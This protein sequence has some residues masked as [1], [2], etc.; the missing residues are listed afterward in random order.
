MI[1]R[2]VLAVAVVAG[3]YRVDLRAPA[4]AAPVAERAAAYERLRPRAVADPLVLADGTTVRYAEDV[5]PVV[6]PDGAAAAHAR[7]AARAR[8]GWRRSIYA[9][10]GVA[11]A[12][13]VLVV[14]GAEN[15]GTSDLPERGPTFG[16]GVA[17]FIAGGA[18]AGVGTW[19]FGARER[20][21]RRA[22][23]AAYDEGLRARLALCVEGLA[24]VACPE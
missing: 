8:R 23:F 6:A 15:R 17:L 16:P 21:A 1:A 2:L 10:I 18:V 4:P 20:E 11:A 22:A 5:L 3:C 7:R 13:M 12:G 19:Y 9:A 24:I 14:A